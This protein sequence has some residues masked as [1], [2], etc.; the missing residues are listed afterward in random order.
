MEIGPITQANDCALMTRIKH[1]E[2]ELISAK[3]LLQ[4]P[5]PK[6]VR[7]ETKQPYTGPRT[8]GPKSACYECGGL[9]HFG[10]DCTKCKARLAREA[11]AARNME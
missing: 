8:A 3:A 2:K 6:P 1:L 7:T 4:K 5:T 10:R 11:A 9:A